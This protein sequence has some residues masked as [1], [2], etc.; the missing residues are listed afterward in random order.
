MVPM[1]AIKKL[2]FPQNWLAVASALA[3]VFTINVSVLKDW[4]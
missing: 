3:N 4:Q 2:S 1:V